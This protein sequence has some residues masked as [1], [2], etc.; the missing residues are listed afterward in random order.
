VEKV[1]FKISIFFRSRKRKPPLSIR[2]CSFSMH[3]H[4]I[5]F[6]CGD[7]KF[8]LI[9]FPGH[10]DKSLKEKR[11]PTALFFGLRPLP[12]FL[13]WLNKVPFLWMPFFFICIQINIWHMWHHTNKMFNG[14]DQSQLRYKQ[15]LKN[16]HWKRLLCKLHSII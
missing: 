9:F 13:S 3:R 4:F 14:W 16:N 7:V 10:Y 12:N 11:R 15:I 2:A 5:Y 6:F 1:T 8:F